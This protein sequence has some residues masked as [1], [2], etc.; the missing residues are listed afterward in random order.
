[1]PKPR[2]GD[3]TLRGSFCRPSG[4]SFCF[5]PASQGC[6]HFVR[7]PYAIIFV[8]F[9]DGNFL[10]LD[11]SSDKQFRSDIQ[12][13]R[14]FAIRRRDRSNRRFANDHERLWRRR[15]GQT[16]VRRDG[17]RRRHRNGSHTLAQAGQLE[18]TLDKPSLFR[19]KHHNCRATRPLPNANALPAESTG[20]S[21]TF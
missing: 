8:A 7:L 14:L 11:A 6:A 10:L 16:E 5:A 3:R 19:R 13:T 15:H 2:R 4:A 20:T 12:S 1:M 21:K 9:G 18:R 17:D